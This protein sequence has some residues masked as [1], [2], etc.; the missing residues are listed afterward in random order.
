LEL[1]EKMTKIITK[2]SEI[3]NQYD[4]LFVDLW[5]CVHDGYEPFPDAVDALIEYRKSGGLVIL[6][7]NAPRHS[8][9]VKKQLEKIGVNKTSWDSIATSGDSARYGMFQGMIGSKVY[10]M[11]QKHDQSFFEPL[12]L[13]DKPMDISQVSLEDAEGIVCCGPFDPT[14]SPDINREAFLYAKKKGLKLLCA[15]PDIVVDRGSVREWC[16]GALAAFYS[17]LGGES[18]YF[19]KPHSPIYSLARKKLK[20]LK[21][22]GEDNRILCI[23]DGINTDIQ[24]ALNQKIDSLFISGGLASSET[25]TGDHP[26]EDLLRSFLNK[27]NSSPTWTIGKLR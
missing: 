2:L 18:I 1:C 10:F 5:G 7:T 16:A 24:G 23:G 12:S 17:E 21:F 15:N 20:D 14:A 25:G 3:S 27:E 8:K 13:E 9:S 22:F 6:V 26:E 4:A 19:G 11:G